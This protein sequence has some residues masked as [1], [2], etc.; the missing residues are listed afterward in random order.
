[1]ATVYIDGIPYEVDPEKNLLDTA[2]SLGLDLPYFCWHPAMGSIGACRQC[3]VK[4]FKDEK[5]TRGRIVMACMTPSTD[6]TRISI[7]DPEAIEARTASTEWL[8][9]NH[10][11]DCP[12]CDEGGECH[13]QDMTVMTG[14][15][16]RRYRFDKRTHRNQDLGPFINHEMNRCIECY[17][18]VRFYRD[19]AGGRDFEVFAA[20][21]NVYFGRQSDGK[22]ESEFSGNLVEICPTG[23]F[24]DKSLKQHFTR[25]WDLQTAPSICVHC[26][27]GC[28]IIPGERYGQLRR[29]RN[30]YNHEVNG[31]FLCD[32]GRYGYEFVNSSQR[33][34]KP[35]I[36][37]QENDAPV[38]VDRQA[39]LLY[40]Q[41]ILK[42]GST[43][44][45]IGSPRASLESNYA[46]Q[47]LVGKEH[48]HAGLSPHDA[49]LM[50]T[51][52]H[53]LQDG[54]VPAASLHEAAMS[55]VVVV[56]G[57]DL[58]NTAP[59]LALALRQSIRNK[60][61]EMARRV[62]IESWNDYSVR[63]ATLGQKGPLFL[64][65]PSSTHLDDA[66]TRTI[67]LA[68]DDIARLGNELAHRID[69][70]VPTVPKTT[71]ETGALVEDVAGYLLDAKSPLIVSGTSLGNLAVLQA[72]ANLAWALK[73][74]GKDSKLVF[75]VPECN[76]LGLA[77]LDHKD[78][79]S[80]L[81]D[82][83][84]F[85]D[86]T[87]IILENDLYRR[88]GSNLIDSLLRSARNVIVL[89]HLVNAT[90]AKA[91]LVLPVATFAEGDGT[92]VNNESR[93][94]R[95][96]Q[97]MDPVDEIQESWR[98]ISDFMQ[99]GDHPLSEKWQAFDDVVQALSA[100]GP[101]FDPLAR[102][103]PP[104]SYRFA[105]QKIPRQPHRYSGRT[106]MRAN[107][108]VNE[109]KPP[110]DPDTA[111]SFS[112]EGF[113]GQPPSALLTHYWAP[114]WNSVQSLNKFQEEVGGPLRGGDPGLRLI[115]PRENADTRYFQDIPERYT[116]GKGEYL[117][118]PLQHIFGSEELSVIAPS[119]AK[120]S[121]QL[122]LALNRATAGDLEVSDGQMVELVLEGISLNLPVHL[123]DSMAAGVFGLP[124]GHPGVPSTL[125]VWGKLRPIQG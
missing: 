31:Y 50:D 60:P 58:P 18:C 49:Q 35:M 101:L 40:I 72:S 8:M 66:A 37:K 84:K 51:V 47:T 48:F 21:D 63:E 10:P 61:Q 42:S 71:G 105:G 36:R 103:A 74:A 111:L 24:T 57:E 64:A 89:D 76:S 80:A 125:P 97:V 46:L 69:P 44:V 115:H 99:L 15:V 26:S 91:N 45:G 2:L 106:S 121:P 70:T 28:N 22:L 30:R 118:L 95:Y 65:T 93:A 20:H 55:D 25:K 88:A 85:H 122:T 78:L 34:R 86:A 98:W 110:D 75:A 56:L 102:L 11:H 123:L 13:L 17:R 113:K 38:T 107:I 62:K 5:D 79:E 96:F 1:V 32:R 16:Y 4:Q 104:A 117:V 116:P 54:P 112:M 23:V 87:L 120:L 6:G 81:Q 59:M 7:K 43:L 119:I 29:I 100:E 53:I 82:L 67:R 19:Y 27:L 114:G 41:E 109:P 68:P 3:A 14:H 73:K 77:M 90:T 92:L 83:N 39:G 94:Q 33:I 12:V 108:N 9:L 52:L 124:A